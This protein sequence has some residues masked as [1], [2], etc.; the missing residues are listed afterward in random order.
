MRCATT[1]LS[2]L[3]VSCTASALTELHAGGRSAVSAGS[4]GALPPS[5]A[6]IMRATGRGCMSRPQSLPCVSSSHWR[7]EREADGLLGGADA[8]LRS[9]GAVF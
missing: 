3:R 2:R 6:D 8:I 5:S 9:H 7:E 4:A 1:L